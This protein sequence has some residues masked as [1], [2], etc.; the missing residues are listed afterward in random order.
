MVKKKQ[1]QNKAKCENVSEKWVIYKRQS[2]HLPLIRSISKLVSKFFKVS[3]E[4]FVNC[5][6]Y[7][8]VIFSE[9]HR[10]ALQWRETTVW[11]RYVSLDMSVTIFS[12]Y[13]F[14]CKNSRWFWAIIMP[15]FSS[16]KYCHFFG[17]FWHV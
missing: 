7:V 16:W 8:S 5:D 4:N 15:I 11:W 12:L 9:P 3:L 14:L 10:P 13:A 17:P 2:F 6:E 1:V